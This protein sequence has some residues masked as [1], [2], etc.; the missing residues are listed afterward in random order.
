ML[1]VVSSSIEGQPRDVQNGR[2]KDDVEFRGH[3]QT[4]VASTINV[5]AVWQRVCISALVGVR[6]LRDIRGQQGQQEIAGVGLIIEQ[7]GA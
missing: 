4:P 7:R 5:S 3:R 1:S 6:A 2:L